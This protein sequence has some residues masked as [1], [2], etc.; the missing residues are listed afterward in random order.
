MITARTIWKIIREH[1]P[2]KRWVSRDEL[3]NLVE[4][5]GKLDGE[6]WRPPSGHSRMPR[7]KVLV[8]E[9]LANRLKKGKI[10]SQRRSD[11]PK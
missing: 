2:K 11:P 7:W 9:V 3:Y 10:R 8:R 6:D 5:H 1:T 4:L